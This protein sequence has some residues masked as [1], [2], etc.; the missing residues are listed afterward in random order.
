[1][2]GPTARPARVT[3][4]CSRFAL[5]A[6]Q[7]F[8]TGDAVRDLLPRVTYFLDEP[9]ETPVS[10]VQYLLMGEARRAGIKVVLNGH[11]SDEALG[12]YPHLFVPTHLPHLPLS[13]HLLRSL[14]PPP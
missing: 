4:M 8:L 12:G 14:R 1:A 9:F 3:S 7:G 5:G 10:L 11:G 2:P 13:G 6:P